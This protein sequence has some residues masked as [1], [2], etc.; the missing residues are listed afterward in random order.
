MCRLFETIRI[1]NGMPR[2]L[3]WHE[4]RMNRARTE[5]WTAG[6]LSGLDGWIRVPPEFSTGIVRCKIQYGP[7]IRQVSFEKYVK[8]DIR[9]LKMVGSSGLDYHLKYADRSVLESLFALRGTADEIIIVDNGLITDTSV[10]NLIFYDGK[11]WYTPSNPLLKGTSRER[12]LAEGKVIEREISQA[13]LGKY[14]G[15]KLINAMRDPGEETM[16]P[17]SEIF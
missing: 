4:L 10:S 8:R 11:R 13:E 1:E 5:L 16:I 7:E 9:S 15:C 3:A 6:A 12:L 2:H 17:V 14:S